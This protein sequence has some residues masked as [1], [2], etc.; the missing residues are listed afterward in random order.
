MKWFKKKK[1]KIYIY[2]D[3]IRLFKRDSVYVYWFIFCA[4]F[5][6]NAAFQLSK[7]YIWQIAHIL[8]RNIKH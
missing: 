7:E 6:R 3:I 5:K 2:T 8:D 1:K 4:D